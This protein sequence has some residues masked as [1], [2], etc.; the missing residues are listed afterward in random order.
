M[1]LWVNYN[2]NRHY[3]SFSLILIS[4]KTFAQENQAPQLQVYKPIFL[5]NP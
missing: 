2:H 5:E 3:H 4:K 1:L